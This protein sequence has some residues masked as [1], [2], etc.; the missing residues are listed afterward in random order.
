MTDY[1][2]TVMPGAGKTTVLRG[3]EAKCNYVVEEAATDV[4]ALEQAMGIEKPWE[5][6]KFIDDVVA[7]QKQRQILA[8]TVES[9]KV[10]FDR[11]PVCTYALCEYLGFAPTKA[12]L[13]EIE[14]GD[15]V[16]NK[17]VFF[18]ENLGFI[19]N[20]D[21]RQ[22]SFNEAVKFEEFHKKA[23]SKFGYEIV[24]VPKMDVEDR[25][26]FALECVQS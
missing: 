25:V 22:I 14:R 15:S 5:N 3:L 19:T 18:V 13:Q 17:K 23:Y 10:F 2:L 9:E 11:S 26:E 8:S 4:I 6:V 1:I 16:Y 7:L 21:A 24:C 12:L 20:T